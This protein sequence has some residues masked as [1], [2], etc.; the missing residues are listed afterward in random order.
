M[1]EGLVF[2]IGADIGDLEKGISESQKQLQQFGQTI[3]ASTSEPLKTATSNLN[4]F[5]KAVVKTATDVSSIKAPVANGANALT[6]L[7]QVT[8]DLPFGF[9]AIQNNL[10]QV[11]DSFG[12]LAKQAGGTGPALKSLA[13]SLAGPAGV[14]FAFGA[15]IAGVTAL[16]QKYGSLGEAFNV[17][18]G[19]T[20]EAT[21]GQKA[22]NKSL[23]EA[24]GN[25]A[26]EEAKINIL[27][28]TLTNNKKP[29][30]DRIAAYGELKKIAPDVVS[31]IKDEN[32]LTAES[33]L[34]IQANAAARKE[35]VRLKIQEAGISAALVTN[36][37]KLAELRQKLTKADQDYVKA[38]AELSKANQQ[39]VITGFASQNQQQRALTDFNNS[40]N[41]VKEL[42]NQINIIT[43]EQDN[44][45]GQLDPIA[46]GIAKINEATRKRVD[47]LKKQGK[48][49]AE[50][51]KIAKQ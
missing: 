22:F 41:A 45:L 13:A 14:S 35:S 51:L 26:A 3:K 42:R 40:V 27:T 38:S 46:V 23:F 11:V 2:K 9:I 34:L 39:Q 20:K 48:A 49:E 12:A 31:G 8:R 18:L 17:I 1:N 24:A 36:E 32:A 47:E 30:E 43:K 16:I 33:N 37:T 21:E 15:V 4:T 19:I 6:S 44:Y 10:P 50:S 5:D 28:K 29:Q 7:S 25:A